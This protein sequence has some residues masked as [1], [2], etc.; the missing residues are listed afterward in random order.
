MSCEKNLTLTII[1]T[2]GVILLCSAII[3]IGYIYNDEKQ[4]CQYNE[5]DNKIGNYDLD[6]SVIINQN[7]KNIS[8]RMIFYDKNYFTI[9]ID[10]NK[11]AVFY[12]SDFTINN[13]TISPNLGNY[14]YDPKQI[15]YDTKIYI[16]DTENN[17]LNVNF[18][19]NKNTSTIFFSNN[20]E[21]PYQKISDTNPKDNVRPGSKLFTNKF[22]TISIGI[23]FL[24]L[25]K[26]TTNRIKSSLVTININDPSSW[27]NSDDPSYV[28]FIKLDKNKIGSDSSISAE[29][30]FNSTPSPIYAGDYVAIVYTE[31]NTF[32]F[33]Y[34]DGNK[35]LTGE[36]NF[37]YNKRFVFILN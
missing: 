28:F 17:F 1:I 11:T 8:C 14:F 9:K 34:L 31:N 27:Q 20:T 30:E 36:T 12:Y 13:N 33:L 2:I 19:L 3:N 18:S 35:T 15:N 23:Q 7:T 32:Y 6:N 4:I 29:N 10:D 16:S 24:K 26:T 37:N 22:V 21:P 5:T 25:N